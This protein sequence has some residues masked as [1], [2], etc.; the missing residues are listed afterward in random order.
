MVTK[1][2]VNKLLNKGLTGMEAARLII[3]DSVEVDHLR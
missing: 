3:L 1:K 2:D